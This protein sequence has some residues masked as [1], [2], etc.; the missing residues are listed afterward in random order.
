MSCFI[1]LDLMPPALSYRSPMYY[2]DC[3]F[4][5][6]G[7]KLMGAKSRRSRWRI[8]KQPM[9]NLAGN[10]RQ[11][12]VNEVSTETKSPPNLSVAPVTPIGHPVPISPE[13]EF[14]VRD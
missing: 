7:I 2:G 8:A 13:L 9:R 3:F 6:C 11:P 14:H 5:I 4:D 1:F 12:T 10:H